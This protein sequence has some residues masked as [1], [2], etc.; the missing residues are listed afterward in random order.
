MKLDMLIT[1]VPF[2]VLVPESTALHSCD[3]IAF[4]MEKELLNYQVAP[5]RR[6]NSPDKT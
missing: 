2:F 3:G 6:N 4:P 1:V 5:M